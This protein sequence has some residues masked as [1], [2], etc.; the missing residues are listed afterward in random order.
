M[1]TI[2]LETWESVPCLIILLVLLLYNLVLHNLARATRG[3][4]L[5][6]GSSVALLHNRVRLLGGGEIYSLAFYV[7]SLEL[8]IVILG[9]QVEVEKWTSE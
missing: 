2:L 7:I 8:N 9:D 3:S 6:R 1:C 4:L 5:T